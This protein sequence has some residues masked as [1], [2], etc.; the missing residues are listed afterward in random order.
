VAD[1]TAN[2]VRRIDI[3]TRAVTTVAGNTVSGV[4]TNG[5]LVNGVGTFASFSGPLCL[6]LDLSGTNLYVADYS[7]NVI[8]AIA[9]AT[10]QVTTFV[11]SG[12]AGYADGLGAA[13]LLNKA[14]AVAVGPVS[15]NVYFADA[16]HIR[17]AVPAPPPSASPHH[18]RTSTPTR[19]GASPS[20][21]RPPALYTVSFL[22]GGG[23]STK[24]GFVDG[25]GSAALFSSPNGLV[26]SAGT[27]FIADTSKLP[28][29]PTRRPRAS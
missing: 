16:T 3:A 8:R 13:V 17:V 10:R 28:S 18:T 19:P 14:Q 4:G 20:P 1:Y 5:A 2:L 11:G 22:A 24:A 9:L 15:G 29:A 23:S 12:A 21:S 25:D 27:I 7:N 26:F 6:A